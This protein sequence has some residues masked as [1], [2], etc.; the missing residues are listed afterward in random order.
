MDVGCAPC[1]YPGAAP[2][3]GRGR[4]RA[5]MPAIRNGVKSRQECPDLLFDAAPAGTAARP[6]L[7]LLHA[8]NWIGSSK[9][10]RNAFSYRDLGVESI[11][12]FRRVGLQ[13]SRAANPCTPTSSANCNGLQQ[14]TAWPLSWY[15]RIRGHA[16]AS[17][18]E[19]RSGRGGRELP[20]C[21][22]H[23]PPDHEARRW[24]CSTG[25]G[26]AGL[27]SGTLPMKRPGSFRCVAVAMI[28]Y[29]GANGRERW[30][31]GPNRRAVTTS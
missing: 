7:I 14:P 4:T 20:V 24:Q 6:P 21:E 16:R 8:P 31:G 10:T 19:A 2:L 23:R 11:K 30:R 5:A 26:S 15:A 18:G 12:I 28:W 13:R 22:L 27:A 17:E 9:I 1:I 25:P 29:V 3:K